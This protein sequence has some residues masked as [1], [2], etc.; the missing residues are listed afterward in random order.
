MSRKRRRLPSLAEHS[1]NTIIKTVYNCNFVEEEYKETQEDLKVIS[2]KLLLAIMTYTS[3]NEKLFVMHKLHCVSQKY[4]LMIKQF[5]Q[6]RLVFEAIFSKGAAHPNEYFLIIF[7]KANTLQRSRISQEKTIRFT[8]YEYYDDLVEKELNN[9]FLN[10]TN[11]TLIEKYLSY[12]QIVINYSLFLSHTGYHNQAENVFNNLSNSIRKFLKFFNSSSKNNLLTSTQESILSSTEIFVKLFLFTFANNTQIIEYGKPF[13]DNYLNF[14]NLLVSK[15]KLCGNSDSFNSEWLMR[16][17]FILQLARYTFLIGKYRDSFHFIK[18]LTIDLED[19]NY[20]KKIPLRLVIETF[21]QASES[22]MKY[23][24]FDIARDYIESSLALIH[25][26][27]LPNSIQEMTKKDKKDHILY[28]TFK[29]SFWCHSTNLLFLEC[30]GVFSRVLAET[31]NLWSANYI[32]KHAYYQANLLVGHENI[33]VAQLY[34]NWCQI[35]YKNKAHQGRIVFTY[36]QHPSFGNTSEDMFKATFKKKQHK[37][38]LYIARAKLLDTRIIHD[39]DYCHYMDA[40][41]STCSS[42][43]DRCFRREKKG[44]ES[45]RK[46]E[47]LEFRYNRSWERA[48]IFFGENSFFHA[49]IFYRLAMLIMQEK[50]YKNDC[51]YLRSQDKDL[52]DVE[53]LLI[54]ALAIE[55]SH[56]GSK[57]FKVLQHKSLYWGE[58]YKIL[59]KINKLSHDQTIDWKNTLEMCIIKINNLFGPAHNTLLFC[60]LQLKYIY[61]HNILQLDEGETYQNEYKYEQLCETWDSIREAKM[62][63]E[64]ERKNIWM[65]FPVTPPDNYKKENIEKHS[66]LDKLISMYECFVEDEDEN[67]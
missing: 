56:L 3:F 66:I 57:H 45:T 29:H 11:P 4:P 55:T 2:P 37:K 58:F 62:I 18:T 44:N 47:K 24:Y 52:V 5:L 8:L 33:T 36:G 50:F 43:Q 9:L 23:E 16:H 42:E 20:L 59:F 53:K 31:D 17:I 40:A 48:N 13:Y 65:D 64:R 63:I 14:L 25:Y 15:R 67:T 41:E 28:T 46:F 26:I 51:H 27:I 32:A 1:L 38:T 19:E 34:S 61:K 21:M 39:C 60:Y 54:N 35:K 30:L 7:N 12:I 6:S 49:E 10:C 22:Y